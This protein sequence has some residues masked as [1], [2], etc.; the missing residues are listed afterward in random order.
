[1][2][3]LIRSSMARKISFAIRRR[4]SCG[5]LARARLPLKRRKLSEGRAHAVVA[6]ARM[7]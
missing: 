2:P 3:E 4:A 7:L 1:M 6:E 5:V